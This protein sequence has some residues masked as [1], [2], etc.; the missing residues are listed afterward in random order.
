VLFQFGFRHVQQ[1]MDVIAG[2]IDG[3]GGG[4][5]L[6]GYFNPRLGSGWRAIF[7]DDGVASLQGRRLA[8][9]QRDDD[10]RRRKMTSSSSSHFGQILQES[11]RGRQYGAGMVT[12]AQTS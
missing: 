4:G 10:G 8:R 9:R 7:T 12:N 2:G 5:L 11:Q 3:G 6:A 1:L